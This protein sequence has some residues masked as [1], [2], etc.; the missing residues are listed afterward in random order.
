MKIIGMKDY[1][2]YGL[3]HG[4][5]P[6]VVLDR[7]NWE[8]FLMPEFSGRTVKK[9]K[10][11]FLLPLR[12]YFCDTIHDALLNSSGR[13]WWN[14]EIDQ[15][16]DTQIMQFEYPTRHVR[17]FQKLKKGYELA[18]IANRLYCKYGEVSDVNSRNRLP[19]LLD[20]NPTNIHESNPLIPIHNLADLKFARIIP[21]LEAFAKIYNF[22]LELLDK[23]PV[24]ND[25][26]S[27]KGKIVSHGFDL[28]TSFRGKNK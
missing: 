28:S 8:K 21:A 25:I 2:D 23:P 5:D 12:L 7:R 20:L 4:V 16:S 1:Y 19:I 14:E 3:M 9:E 17:R 15:V 11:T 10:V 27:N 18:S 13:F 6:K 26:L 22:Q 24:E